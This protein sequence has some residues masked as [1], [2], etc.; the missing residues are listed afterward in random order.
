VE[1]GHNGKSL[2]EGQILIALLRTGRVAV[3]LATVLDVVE[4]A[5]SIGYPGPIRKVGSD[6]MR[7]R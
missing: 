6:N 2:T 3:V 7:K 1:S 5:G 4:T